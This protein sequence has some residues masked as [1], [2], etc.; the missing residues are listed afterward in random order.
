MARATF[1]LTGSVS[2]VSTECASRLAWPACISPTR[3]AEG[4]LL[5]S[6]SPAVA[7]PMGE[8]VVR[9]RCALV[10]GKPLP[11]PGKA[12][13]QAQDTPALPC[14]QGPA[15]LVLVCFSPSKPTARSSSLELG[16]VGSSC[17][18]VQGAPCCWLHH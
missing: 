7:G 15:G 14:V 18:R 8:Y 10:I 9:S 4:G 6:Q 1:P 2:Q 13:L 3:R 16:S 11:Q 12:N 17:V 5:L